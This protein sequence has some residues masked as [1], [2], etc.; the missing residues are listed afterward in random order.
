MGS[1]WRLLLVS[2][3]MVMLISYFIAGARLICLYTALIEG[4]EMNFLTDLG[5]G[6]EVFIMWEVA[7]DEKSSPMAGNVPSFL[8]PYPSL[9]HYRGH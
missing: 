6:V 5:L 8:S 1:M 9:E 4:E 3:V 7:H 2:S